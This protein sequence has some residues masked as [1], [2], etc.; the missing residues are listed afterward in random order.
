MVQLLRSSLSTR[1]S[2]VL[3]VAVRSVLLTAAVCCGFAAI[4]TTQAQMTI[5]GTVTDD[6]GQPVPQAQVLI[7]RLRLATTTGEDGTYQ[8]F[9]LISQRV[10]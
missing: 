3:P 6:F 2:R 5:T 10:N 7:A 4:S 1:P 9:V 8:L